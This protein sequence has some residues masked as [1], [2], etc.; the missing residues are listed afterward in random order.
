MIKLTR[1]DY[2]EALVQVQ[3]ATEDDSSYL[4]KFSV[5]FPEGINSANTLEICRTIQDPSLESR[6]NLMRICT[7]GKTVSVTC[8]NGERESFSLS[9]PSDSIEG[10]PLFKKEPLALIAVADCIYGYV[11]KKSIRLSVAQL[12]VEEVQTQ[13]ASEQAQL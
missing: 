7:A 13:K 9:N 10:F 4:D 11:L 3:K 8:P 5:D 2:K 1:Q 12:T 6:I